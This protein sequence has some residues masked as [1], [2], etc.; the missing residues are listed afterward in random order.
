LFTADQLKNYTVVKHEFLKDIN[1]DAWLLRH[2]KSG[3]R[4]LL[5]PNG[6]DN[7]VFYIGFRTTP[8]DSTGAA[9]IIEHTVLCGSRDFPVKDPF[10]ELAKGSL[11]TFL[12]AMTFPDKTLY[13]VASCNDRDFRNLMHVYMDAVFYPRIYDEKRIFEQEGWHYELEKNDGEL[14]ING[15]VYNEM[16]GVMSSPDDVLERS[17]YASLFPHTTYAVESGGDPENIPDLTY[18]NYLDF[19]R[20]YYHPSNSYLYLY[21]DMD[22]N[23]RLDWIDRAYLSHFDTLTV[24]SE[25]AKEAPFDRP[26]EERRAYSVMED[27]D[28]AGKTFLAYSIALPDSLDPER[29]VLF[30]ILDYV[31]CDAPG[32]PLKE[33]L[34]KKGIG[35]D[36]TSVF[37]D[38]TAQPVWTVTAR[39]CEPEQK[40]DFIETVEDVLRD[41][42]GKG[43]E[44]D[45]LL[46]GINYHEFRYREADFG[47]YPKGLIF[48]LD[49]MSSWLYDDGEPWLGLK[50]GDIYESMKQAADSGLFEKTVQEEILKNPHKS[51]VLLVPEKGLTDRKEKALQEKLENYRKSLP[52]DACDAIVQETA[53]LRAYQEQPDDPEAIRRI[54]L[55]ERADLTKQ[56][57][58]FLTEEKTAGGMKL[59]LHPV[60]TNSICYLS[61]EFDIRQ[62]PQKYFDYIP[63][64]KAVFGMMGTA[65]YSYAALNNRINILT[66]GISPAV[67]SYTDA[68]DRNSYRLLF[69]IG[70]KVLRENLGEAVKLL[71]EILLCTDYSDTRRLMDI[72]EE[73]QSGL[74]ED[75]L[76]SGH[77]T[78]ATR[79]ESYFSETSYI[80]DAISGIGGYRTIRKLCA[81]R[82]ETKEKLPRILQEMAQYIFTSDR[83]VLTNITCAEEDGEAA[84]QAADALRRTLPSAGPDAGEPYHIVLRKKNEGFA[85]AGQVQYVC[86]AGSF[87]KDRNSYDGALRV[88]RVI[89]GYDYLWNMIRVKGGAYGC[90]S[91]F[92]H[93]G[94]ACFVTYRDPH[95]KES[96]DT[97]LQAPEYL[98][99]FDADE[100]TMTQYVIGAISSLD[101]PMTPSQFGK[102]CLMGYLSHYTQEQVQKERDEV[103]Q[104]RPEDIRRLSDAVETFLSDDCLCVVGTAR[105][106]GENSTLFGTTEKLL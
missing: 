9:H 55:L 95:L 38:G 26:V 16:K 44:K 71:E 85:A 97:F 79:A 92:G 96:I 59:L 45:A 80:Q 102:Y 91:N 58:A 99:K 98:R 30:R 81:Q 41:I 75:L 74:R 3:A 94:C 36:I 93:D 13:P 52:P 68:E 88:L 50:D 60:F 51:I 31:L 103:L 23:E 27:E 4:I 25:V 11:N 72:L 57:V 69:E 56:A 46:A 54:P 65:S 15:V 8:Q 32:A 39:Y 40:A 14:K 64:F 86:R 84:G 49:C 77:V 6:D 35:R 87:M 47:S 2:T 17:V 37:D 106:I 83:L 89:L 7:K 29:N 101:T 63:V 34:L 90:M 33:A 20:R 104:C 43:F 62:L 70:V 21:G 12:N 42:A 19:H 28:E 24:D 61:F 1:S 5:L 100:H 53:R 10:I 105:M 67:T 48:G 66:G 78:A 18:E 22:M 73:E 76:A 82:K